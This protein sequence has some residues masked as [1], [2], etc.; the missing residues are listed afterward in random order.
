MRML[1][2]LF[3]RSYLQVNEPIKIENTIKWMIIQ[4]EMKTQMQIIQK[5]LTIRATKFL[6]NCLYYLSISHVTYAW[7]WLHNFPRADGAKRR[8]RVLIPPRLL[9]PEGTN[10]PPGETKA[11]AKSK[12][13]QWSRA[14]LTVRGWSSS[15]ISKILRTV[16]NSEHCDGSNLKFAL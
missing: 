13:H 14:W 10:S 1:R 5:T 15:L 2:L 8:A 16:M 7:T 12:V 3:A 11:L 9:I 6:I 4:N